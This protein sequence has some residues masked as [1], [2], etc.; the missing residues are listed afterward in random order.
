MELLDMV[1]NVII[2]SITTQTKVF[3]ERSILFDRNVPYG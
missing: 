2:L 3:Q 1:C